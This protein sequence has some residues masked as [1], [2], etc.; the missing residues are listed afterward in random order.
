MM[1]SYVNIQQFIQSEDGATALEY[2]LMASLIAAAT[3]GAQTTMGATVVNMY[4][5]AIGTITP[6]QSR[7]IAHLW[8]SVLAIRKLSAMPR[9]SP[10]MLLREAARDQRSLEP[11][12]AQGNPEFGSLGP[13]LFIRCLLDVRF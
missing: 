9:M 7:N 13:E 2:A 4:T 11:R 10:K 8:C 1:K 6:C 12:L 3:V 5:V